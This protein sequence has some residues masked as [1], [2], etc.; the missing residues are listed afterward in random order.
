MVTELLEHLSE[1]SYSL[2]QLLHCRRSPRKHLL[3]QKLV[4]IQS[5]N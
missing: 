4:L 5:L 1:R 3:S 2:H